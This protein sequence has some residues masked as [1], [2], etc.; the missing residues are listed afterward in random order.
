MKTIITIFIVTILSMITA[1]MQAQE[2]FDAV[3]NN[4]LAKVRT[5]VGKNPV[6]VNSKDDPGNTPLHQAATTGSVEIAGY[7]LSKG[8]DIDAVNARQNTPLHEAIQSRKENVAMFLIEKGAD[9]NKVNINKQTPLHRAVLN[10]QKGIGELI[11]AKG[12]LIDP[13]DSWGRTPFLLV[14][15]QTGNVEFGKLL[16]SKGADMNAKDRDNLMALNLAAW[17]GFTGFIDLLLDRGAG[18]DTTRGKSRQILS[19]AASGGCLRLFQVIL[20]NDKSLLS[21]EN[22]RRNIIRTAV[23][24]GSVDIVKFLLSKNI[25]LNNDANEYGWTPLHYAAASGHAAM[26]RFLKENNIDIDKRTSSGKS[27]YNIAEENKKDEVLKTI[28]ELGGDT[29]DKKFPQLS[30]PYLGQTPPTGEPEIFAP[31][32]VASPIEDENHSSVSFSPD[33]KEIYWN[34]SNKIWMTTLVNDRW[35]EPAM[36]PFCMEDSLMYDNPFIT[37]DGKTMFFTSGRPGAVGSWKENIWYAE[38]TPSGWDVP[39]PVSAEVN[40]MQLHWSISISRTGTLYWA[41]TGADHYGRG[42]IYCSQMVNGVYTKPVNMGPEINTENSETCPHIAQDESY[43]IFTRLT[44]EGQNFYI[45]YRAK[46]GQ[47]LPAVKIHDEFEGVS[48]RVSPDGKYFFFLG[49]GANG[50]YWMPAIFIDVLRPKE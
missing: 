45:S 32:I 37:L 25:P 9:V 31:D 34:K 35:A 18:Y 13:I 3:K 19:S 30:G 43:I 8:A 28:R 5:L 38:R 11:I 24:G 41:G 17:R 47:W 40:A 44:S 27:V 6:L 4:D 29:S 10:D 15:R 7:L 33:G 46:S 20:N 26:I 12:A 23:M 1:Q 48:A 22:F 50:I 2:I 39:K 21:G 36:V 42:D 14:A 49:A 16:L